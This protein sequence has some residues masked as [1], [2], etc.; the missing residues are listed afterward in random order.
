V[1]AG[2]AAGHRMPEGVHKLAIEMPYSSSPVN[3][4][5]IEG[6]PLTLVDTGPNCAMSLAALEAAL[7]GHGHRLEDLERV[8]VTHPHIDHFGLASVIAERAGAEICAIDSSV[9]WLENYPRH[10]AIQAVFRE[11]LMTRHGVPEPLRN[12]SL[13]IDT[14]HEEWDPSVAVTRT[15][16]VGETVEFAN[17]E[18][19]VSLRPGHSPFD[20]I[21]HDERRGVLFV[22]DHLISNIS[23]NPVITPPGEGLDIPRPRA[24]LTYRDSLRRTQAMELDHVLAGHGGEIADHRELIDRRFAGM[25]RRRERV[26]AALAGGAA[27]A[28]EVAR[29]LWRD[30]AE[31]EPWL[32]LTEV[33]GYLDILGEAGVVR[34]ETDAGAI[35]EPV[36]LAV[37]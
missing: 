14:V 19:R 22:G 8:L 33:L 12:R 2:P 30:A 15:L 34:E 26:F 11:R 25:E 17:L 3:L 18:L 16:R 37:A 28:H 10:R 35:A 24:L 32:T 9:S 6:E 23:S 36:R 29:V 7:A 21:F 31:E 13:A 4:Y 27:N 5:L 20:T 1:S